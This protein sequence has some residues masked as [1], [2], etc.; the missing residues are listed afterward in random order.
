MYGINE[1]H[2]TKKSVKNSVD[3]KSSMELK[4]P[5]GILYEDEEHYT[6]PHLVESGNPGSFKPLDTS[7]Y[8]GFATGLL[9]SRNCTA[10]LIG[11]MS[12]LTLADCVYDSTGRWTEDLDLWR[13]RNCNTYIE[14]MRW[15]SVTIP[16]QFYQYGDSRQTG[17]IL[18]TTPQPRLK[19]GLDL[20]TQLL[21][22]EDRCSC[23]SEWLSQRKIIIWLS[24]S[25]TLSVAW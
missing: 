25:I 21:E 16:Y 13:G 19:T 22:R 4:S 20:V 7:Q 2:I 9:K 3:C 24:F 18:N 17:P 10:F 15:E 12:A 8:P 5:I 14:Q 23:H 1:F 11:K 6:E